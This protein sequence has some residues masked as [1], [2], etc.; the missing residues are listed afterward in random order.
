MFGIG[1]RKPRNMPNDIMMLTTALFNLTLTIGF[2]YAFFIGQR[3]PWCRA[4]V[5]S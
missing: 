3:N 5:A 1:C 2:S 4:S